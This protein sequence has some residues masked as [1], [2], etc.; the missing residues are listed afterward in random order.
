LVGI[1]NPHGAPVL[2][3]ALR[4]AGLNKKTQLHGGA[5]AG[6]LD[7]S[8]WRISSSSTHRGAGRS[9]HPVASCPTNTP[10]HRP[11]R[12]KSIA[13]AGA[14]QRRMLDPADRVLDPVI[15]ISRDSHPTDRRSI[16][17]GIFLACDRP[18]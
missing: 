2:F 15:V 11:R 7:P 5:T 9:K 17:L 6:F 13:A 16:L 12:D 8:Y 3:S 10:D 18:R 14:R 4:P 1:R